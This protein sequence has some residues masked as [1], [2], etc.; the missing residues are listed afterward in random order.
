MKVKVRKSISLIVAIVFMFSAT[1]TSF[2]NTEKIKWKEIKGLVEKGIVIEALSEEIFLASDF[3]NYQY[4]YIDKTGKK[5]TDFI[6][7]DAGKFSEGLAPIYKDYK[8]GYID[9]DGK[10][11]I[12]CTYEQGK[13]FSEGLACVRKDYK[14]GYIDKDGKEVIPCTYEQGKEFSE[15]LACVMKDVKWGYIDKDGKEVIPCTYEQGKEFSEGL[16][17]VMKDGKWGYIDKAGKNAIPF[18]Y[19]EASKFSEGLAPIYKDGKWGYIDK[20]GKVI[21]NPVYVEAGSFYDGL[22]VIVKDYKVGFIDKKGNEIVKPVYETIFRDENTVVTYKDG[23]WLIGSLEGM[24]DSKT[25]E[26]VKEPI[27]N[28]I[29]AKA[30]EAKT[31]VNGKKIDFEAYNIDGNN[32]FKLRDLAKVVS[33]T[34]KQFEIIWDQKKKAV[35]MLSHEAYTVVGG[36]LEKKEVKDEKATVSNSVIYKDGKKAELKAYLIKGNNYFKLRDVAKAFDISIGWDNKTK[37]IT[38]DTTKGY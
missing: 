23:K 1:V 35:N 17:C 11:V 13:E 14:W 37:T 16:A 2:G 4:G 24:V 29:N 32:Y 12:P 26:P 20:T 38:V 9:K 6:Y 22:G 19:D 33:G 36:E 5:I 27:K 7:S 8:Y 34:E 28:F 31:L 3:G 25:E 30:T 18:I 15:G 10:E 21:I